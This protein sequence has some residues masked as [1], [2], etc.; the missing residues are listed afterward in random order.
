MWKTRDSGSYCMLL[1]YILF[2]CIQ[3]FWG[4]QVLITSS[5]LLTLLFLPYSSII[6]EREKQRPWKSLTLANDF[7]PE[8]INNVTIIKYLHAL[9]TGWL[10]TN[11]SC[12]IHVQEILSSTCILLFYYILLSCKRFLFSVLC[13]YLPF[14]LFWNCFIGVLIHLAP[15][16]LFSLSCTIARDLETYHHISLSISC[17]IAVICELLFDIRQLLVFVLS[18]CQK[19][20]ALYLLVFSVLC[21]SIL[22]CKYA[23]VIVFT[24]VIC[25]CVEASYDC[26]GYDDCGH[27]IVSYLN[28]IEVQKIR[29]R[30]RPER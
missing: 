29:N 21:L 17:G 12:I 20:R 19:K 5:F 28:M 2:S 4:V 30:Y 25:W 23:I 11:Y 7:Y 27:S 10:N 22:V 1:P 3:V 13:C 9:Q 18:V 16:Y 14:C 24:S 8:T 6:P 15:S 26:D